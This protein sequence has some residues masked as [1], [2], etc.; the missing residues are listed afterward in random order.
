MNTEGILTY[1]DKIEKGQEPVGSILDIVFL[2]SGQVIGISEETI[3][4]YRTDH[5]YQKLDENSPSVSRD[6]LLESI[7]GG[8]G[9]HIQSAE[10]LDT[11][12]HVMVDRL[13]LGT[14]ESVGISD[15]CVVL[16]GRGDEWLGAVPGNQVIEL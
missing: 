7:E 15:D 10:T 2:K 5:D 11:G 4:L 16:Y 13:Q 14:G 3:V 6:P 8:I 9:N 12:G 1:V